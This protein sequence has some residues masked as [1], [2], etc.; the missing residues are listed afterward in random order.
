MNGLKIEKSTDRGIRN[1]KNSE[2][3]IIGQIDD[4]NR[5][6]SDWRGKIRKARTKGVNNAKA[7][8]IAN[9][10]SYLE[11]IEN[12][13]IDK[14]VSKE[15]YEMFLE[16]GKGLEGHHI[17]NVANNPNYA[18]RLDNIIFMSRQAHKEAHSGNFQNA[19]KGN[20][21]KLKCKLK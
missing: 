12:R 16:T 4:N 11:A 6:I 3:R 7:C 18:N 1:I 17:K 8:I 15:A 19:T 20:F 21:T 5:L 14:S 13:V 10:L 9:K 2:G